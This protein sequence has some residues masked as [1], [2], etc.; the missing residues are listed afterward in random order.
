MRN[1]AKCKLCKSIIESFHSTDYVMCKC[2]EII[3]DGGNSMRCGANNFDNF[4]RIDDKDNEIVPKILSGDTIKQ[5]LI[6]KNT[7][8][9]DRA[10]LMKML[11][12]M[13]GNMED[14]PKQ[15]LETYVTHYDLMSA[16]MLLSAILR[17][18]E[19]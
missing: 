18:E 5:D 9:P 8:K 15:A 6:D 3:V 4:L 7:K 1:R 11:E 2:G 17:S 10:E 16:L 12:Y 19:A 14:L 13:I